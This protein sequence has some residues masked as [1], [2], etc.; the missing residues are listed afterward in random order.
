MSAQIT[1]IEE[2][3]A[4]QTMLVEEL[5]DVV[6]KQSEEI[7][8]LKRHVTMLVKRAAEEE[9]ANQS[10]VVIGNEQPPHY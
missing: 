1:K 8:L 7:A 2:A 10:G 9:A 6:A 3:L 4:H 5:N